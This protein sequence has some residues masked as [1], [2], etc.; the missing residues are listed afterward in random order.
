L[1]AVEVAAPR[2]VVAV[3]LAGIVPQLQESRQVVVLRL[4]PFFH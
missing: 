2:T 3:V 1:P 4:K